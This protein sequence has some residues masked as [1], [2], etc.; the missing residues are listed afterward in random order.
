MVCY[1]ETTT[2]CA[3]PPPCAKGA[4][5]VA[6][7]DGACEP[8]THSACVPRYVPPCETDSDCGTGFTC[9]LEQSGCGC[10]SAGSAGSSGSAGSAT[11]GNTPSDG[12]GAKP[13]P[14]G[15]AGDGFAPPPADGGAD[16]A[17]PAD[18]GAAPAP[19]P[20]DGGAPPPDCSCPASTV[21]ACK[22]K[23]TACEAASDCP[24]GFTCE[25]NPADCWA[26]SDGS[27]GCNT[28]DPA[29]ICAPPY[30]ELVGGVGSHGSA[31]DS[32]GTATGG[33]TQA[34]EPPKG[35]PADPG[36]TNNGAPR[37]ID[38]GEAHDSSGSGCSVQPARG[39][40][41]ESLALFGLALVGLSALRRRR[42]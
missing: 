17:P 4:D 20:S 12:S 16:P 22:L 15:G 36:E 28:P 24:A 27:S 33:D 8:E 13:A 37:D 41:G 29:K 18:G 23:V 11:P 1:T 39:Q 34:G 10:A 38:P 42:A 30:T 19:V 21:K 9:E 3:D 5:C 14:D 31:E 7:A 26:S 32:S 2:L 25:D 35:A 6:P 40:T